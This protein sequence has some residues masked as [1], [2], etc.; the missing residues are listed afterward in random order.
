MNVEYSDHSLAHSNSQ[1]WLILETEIKL[2]KLHF[3]KSTTTGPF[4]YFL[5]MVVLRNAQCVF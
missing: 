3:I 4:Y 2:E 5:N 1:Q